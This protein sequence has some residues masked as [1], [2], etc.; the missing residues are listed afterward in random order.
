[1]SKRPETEKQREAEELPISKHSIVAAAKEQVSCDL[2]GEAV[3]LNLES[4]VYFGLNNLGARVWS[5]VQEPTTVEKLQEVL[6]EEYDVEPER[7]ER[8]L[9]ALLQKL[10]E[11]GLVGVRSEA[12]E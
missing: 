9:L 12:G 8:D 5:L 4:G 2:A 11:A 3:I 7:C 10:V 6:L 1:M